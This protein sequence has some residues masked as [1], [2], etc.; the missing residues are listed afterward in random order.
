MTT[1]DLRHALGAIRRARELAQDL[2]RTKAPGDL[3]QVAAGVRHELKAA[4]DTLSAALHALE[5]D[6]AGNRVGKVR[7]DA[8]ATSRAAA[9]AIVV[10]SGTQRHAVL[11]KLAQI[12]GGTGATDLELQ[13][14]TGLN[15]SSLRPRRGELVDGGYVRASEITRK[16]GKGDEWRVWELT[17]KGRLVVAELAPHL[18]TEPI[19][20]DGALF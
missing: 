8:E 18:I 4:E 17:E 3:G 19:A 6:A 5:Q 16:D 2:D 20:E 10:R 12:Y 15:P 7:R 9:Q 11:L 1:S 14:A 13:S